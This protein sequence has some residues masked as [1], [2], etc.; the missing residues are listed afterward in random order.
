MITAPL[1]LIL[2]PAL[3]LIAGWY[4][5]AVAHDIPKQRVDRTLQLQFE[6]GQLNLFYDLELDDTTIAAD[7]KRLRPGPLPADPDQWLEAYGNLVAPKLANGLLLTGPIPADSDK[8]WTVRAIKRTREQ[9][10]IYQFEFTKAI[11]TSGLY[12]LRDTNFG[13]SDGLSRIGV[14]ASHQVHLDSAAKYPEKATSQPYQPAWMLDDKALKETREWAGEVAW[15]QSPVES[16]A[17]FLAQK[18]NL[19]SDR[20]QQRSFLWASF[21]LGLWHTIQP[22]HGKTWVVATAARRPS[23]LLHHLAMLAGWVLSH[24]SVILLLA[25]A[26]S[27]MSPNFLTNFN[28]GLRQLA[29]LMIAGPAAYRLGQA[30]HKKWPPAQPNG[31]TDQITETPRFLSGFGVGLTAGLVPCWEA[32]GLL[33]LG[34]SAGHPWVGVGLVLGFIGGGLLVMI[35]MIGFAGFF[36][37]RLSRTSFVSYL[38]MTAL[39]FAVFVAGSLL[40]LSGKTLT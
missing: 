33:L 25:A 28:L 18:A 21:L 26:A 16:E 11:S 38:F 30:I 23:G 36:S 4:S 32:V 24:F 13:T 8:P 14:A 40:L 31:L 37:T 22:G 1:R 9:H 7:L 15:N 12:R 6:P 27:L 35:L 39:D 17:K 19:P 10:T 20:P 5:G 3:G 2:I 34:F 29:G